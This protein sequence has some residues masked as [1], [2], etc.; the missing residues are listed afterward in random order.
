[1]RFVKSTV[2]Y[3]ASARWPAWHWVGV[4]PW[5]S[6]AYVQTRSDGPVAAPITYAAWSVPVGAVDSEPPHEVDSTP[7]GWTD[8]PHTTLSEQQEP[9]KDDQP[10]PKNSKSTG[11]HPTSQE[12][13]A[14]TRQ[15][16]RRSA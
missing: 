1:M 16:M 4:T 5:R 14:S 12:K 7:T 6:S 10:R 3:T 2:R 8:R 15:T 11:Q 13:R 9:C